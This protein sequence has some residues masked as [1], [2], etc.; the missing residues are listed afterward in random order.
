MTSSSLHPFVRNR[1]T[2]LAYAMLAYIGFSQAILGPLMAFLRSDFG[3]NYTQ[4]GFLPATIAVGLVF[5]GLIGDWL[6]HHISRRVLFWSGGIVLAISVIALSLSRQ[7]WLVIISV[8]GMGFGGS[9]TQIMIQALLSDQHGEGRAIALTEANVAASLS[10]T[11]TP[12]VIGMLQTTAAGWRA[13]SMFAVLLLLLLAVPFRHVPIPGSARMRSQSTADKSHLSVSF[14]LYWM[15]LFLVVAAEMTLAVW[16]TDFLSSV[17]GLSRTNAVLAFG[18]FPAAMLI[19]RFGGS[20]LMRRWSSQT[21]L[22][23]ALGLTLVGFPIFWLSRLAV[24]NIFGLFITGLGI[25]N[26][27]PLTLSVAVGLAAGQT[28]QASARASLGVG[29][30]LLTA[31]LLLGWLADR[32]GLQNAYGIFLVFIIAAFVVVVNKA[33]DWRKRQILD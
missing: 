28:N 15:V 5:S 8:L 32:F 29:A 3:L 16:A 21:L 14:W 31:P 2:W 1:L 30:A 4:G 27:Y 25:A 20:R 13:I 26:L 18:S 7:Y 22:L 11:F 24:F 33:F 9:L 17:A 6:A 10:A 19:G 12:F 23:A